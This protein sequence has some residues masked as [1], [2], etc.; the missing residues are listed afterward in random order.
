MI[1]ITSKWLSVPSVASTHGHLC[2]YGRFRAL[3]LKI[4]SPIHD[5]NTFSCKLSSITHGEP[6][7]HE[8]FLGEDDEY[9]CFYS[10]LTSCQKLM[11]YMKKQS[12]TTFLAVLLY[13]K[14]L[15]SFG[16]FIVGTQRS[17]SKKYPPA[18]KDKA[19]LKI[20]KR[21]LP[22]QPVVKEWQPLF[23]NTQRRC[24]LS[25]LY[26]VQLVVTFWQ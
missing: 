23:R 17:S 1:A 2:T 15:R 21:W 5:V 13:A 20:L 9:L 19:L 25:P 7:K 10:A 22:I 4:F 14:K 26:T 24:C 18:L 8:V 3:N 16:T 11:L 6:K 12:R